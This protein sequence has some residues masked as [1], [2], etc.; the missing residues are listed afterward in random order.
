MNPVTNLW[1]GVDALVEKYPNLSS[2]NYCANNPVKFI[3]KDGNY[4]FKTDKKYFY[5]PLVTSQED[6]TNK[7]GKETKYLFAAGTLFAKSGAYSYD[8][9]VGGHVKDSYTGEYIAG[10]FTT[11]AGSTVINNN[12]YLSSRELSFWEK[13]SA[14]DNFFVQ[15]AYGT[16]ND[17]Y[18]CFQAFDF[19]L[20]ERE[21][22][23][24]PFTGANFGNLDG[25]PN[26]NQIDAIPG[27][28]SDFIPF[29]KAE[30]GLSVLKKMNAAQFSKTF[31]GTL[32][33]LKPSTRGTINRGINS[34][35]DEINSTVGSG[36]VML[37]AIDF[38]KPEDK[39]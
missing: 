4:W 5:D 12:Q 31:K 10:Q 36:E 14:S 9:E 24:N 17:W 11:P 35:I 19:G 23:K 21:E 18:V 27:V 3:D 16:L 13:M 7:Y 39:E 2:Y 30:K 26:Y 29:S 28:I 32:S 38:L 34:G 37:D 25:T 6:A 33:R 8:L 22:W 15:L 20:L 1:Y